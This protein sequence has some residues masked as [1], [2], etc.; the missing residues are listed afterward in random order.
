MEQSHYLL[1]NDVV[2]SQHT[3][4]QKDFHNLLEEHMLIWNIFCSNGSSSEFTKNLLKVFNFY[5]AIN[6]N[7]KGNTQ[8]F[9][10]V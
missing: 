7:K 10:N 5:T 2:T 6:A 9:R 8:G 1:W 3:L 4:K